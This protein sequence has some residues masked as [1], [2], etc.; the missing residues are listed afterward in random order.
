MAETPQAWPS[1]AGWLAPSLPTLNKVIVLRCFH[2]LGICEQ[3]PGSNRSGRID[4]Y[5]KRG[6]SPVGSYWCMNWATSVWVD[7]GAQVPDRSRGS[8]DVTWHWARR[9]GLATDDPV[10]GA[11]VIY[12]NKRTLATGP[13]AGHLDA[14]HVGIIVRVEPYLI[15]AEGNAAWSGFSA[16]GEAVLL[17]RVDTAR[18]LGYV[19]PRAA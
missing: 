11:M 9:Q 2:D 18:V 19:T 10:P 12:T 7:A 14:V 4:T 15:A 8:C 1:V 3:P 17:K 13:F 6:G 16:N 5:N